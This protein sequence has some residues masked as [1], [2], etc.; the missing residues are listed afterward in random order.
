MSEWQR[1]CQKRVAQNMPS[2]LAPRIRLQ[3][4]VKGFPSYTPPAPESRS[5]GWH[6]IIVLEWL[7]DHPTHGWLRTS[8]PRGYAS[9]SFNGVKTMPTEY[10][11]GDVMSAFTKT[12]SP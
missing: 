8:A 12:C 10:S 5:I 9:D 2:A 11:L 7:S 6:Q 1:K 4:R 3:A